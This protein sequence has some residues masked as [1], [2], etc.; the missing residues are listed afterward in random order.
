MVAQR[1]LNPLIGVRIP[2]PQHDC[3]PLSDRGSSKASM[4][5]AEASFQSP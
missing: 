2:V 3:A 4:W 1:T 5:L